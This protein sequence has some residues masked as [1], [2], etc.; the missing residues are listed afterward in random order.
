MKIYIDTNVLIDFVCQRKDFAVSANYLMTLGC[1]GKVNLQTSALSYVTAMF[2]A[3]KYEYENV[4]KSLLSVSNFIEVLD[5]KASTVIEMLSSGWNDYG[6]ALQYTTAL[7]ADADC[8]V[9]RNKKD[10]SNSSLPVYSPDE[11]LNKLNSLVE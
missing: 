4:G 5:L 9:T 3:E 2:V 10:F 6:D 11:F 1:L 8:I 7:W